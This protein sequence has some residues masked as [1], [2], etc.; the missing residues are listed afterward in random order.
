MSDAGLLD[1]ATVLDALAAR[2]QPDRARVIAG[3]LALDTLT[4][5]TTAS[6]DLLDAAAGLQI[7]ATGGTLD[8]DE[9]GLLRAHRFAEA[10]RQLIQFRGA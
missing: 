1:A 8:L 2:T 10:V 9:A 6:P 4:K 3:A 5:T 7:I